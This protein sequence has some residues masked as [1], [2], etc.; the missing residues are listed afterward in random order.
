MI[1]CYLEDRTLLVEILSA[2]LDHHI[3]REV[4]E[5]VDDILFKKQ[6]NYIIFDFKYVNFMDSSGIGVIIGRYK[7]I[8]NHGG[9]VSVINMKPR[10]E[11]VFNLSGMNKI[12]D[13]Y[14][15]FEDAINS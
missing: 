12:I 7:K 15:T 8:V 6:V 4:R 2:E 13:I 11:K 14:E 5:D 9:K 10:V 1:K 3:A